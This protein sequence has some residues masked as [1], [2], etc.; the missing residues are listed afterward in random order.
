MTNVPNLETSA[1]AFMAQK[2]PLKR[3]VEIAAKDGVCRTLEGEVKYRAGDAI[4][5]GESGGKPTL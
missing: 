1:H 5:T 4:M 3:H 2:K